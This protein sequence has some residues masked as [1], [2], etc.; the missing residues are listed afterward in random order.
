MPISCHR[1]T[2]SSP[3]VDD[4]ER[5]LEKLRRIEALAR[6]PEDRTGKGRVSPIRTNVEAAGHFGAGVDLPDDLAAVP[7]FSASRAGASAG[8][9]GGACHVN[10]SIGA[11]A[12]SFTNARSQSPCTTAWRRTKRDATQAASARRPA[13]A[14]F[15]RTRRSSASVPSLPPREVVDE[16]AQ[17]GELSA[18]EA[19]RVNEVRQ[20]QGE[21]TVA[22]RVRRLPK[23]PGDESLPAE[24]RRVDVR[25][26]PFGSPAVR[27]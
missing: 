12:A 17:L 6:K 7:P 18:R 20:E 5:L 8:T 4:R 13:S 2:V 14:A 24:H 22:E 16:A 9:S 10:G 26:S 27:R 11:A 1:R 3:I 25:P 23:T 21:R 15:V 19:A